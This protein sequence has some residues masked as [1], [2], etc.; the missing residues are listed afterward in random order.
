[1]STLEGV[2]SKNDDGS[3]SDFSTSNDSQWV[4]GAKCVLD[5]TDKTLIEHSDELTNKHIQMAQNLLK[6]Q[7][8]LVGGLQ[9]TLKQPAGEVNMFMITFFDNLD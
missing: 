1:M 7:F 5:I 6:C 3:D 2:L 9:N 8:P 4:R